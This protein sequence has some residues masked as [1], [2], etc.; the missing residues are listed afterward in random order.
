MDSGKRGMNPVAM[1]IISPRK[2][3][4]PSRGSNKRPPVLKSCT[5]P[6]VQCRLAN[7]KISK[8]ERQKYTVRKAL[9]NAYNDA[10]DDN[11]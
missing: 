6:T 5:L 3:N 7:D 8:F 2:E 11:Q 4:F 9:Q 1:T 10:G